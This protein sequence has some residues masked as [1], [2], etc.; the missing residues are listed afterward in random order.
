MHWALI[1]NF[2]FDFFL[3]SLK[4]GKIQWQLSAIIDLPGFEVKLEDVAEWVV[5]EMRLNKSLTDDITFNLKIVG[6]PFYVDF[7][8][9]RFS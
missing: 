2:I 4:I 5:R 8:K 1:F 7:L 9:A 3:F 6:R